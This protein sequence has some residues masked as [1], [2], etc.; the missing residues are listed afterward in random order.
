MFIFNF[1]QGRQKTIIYEQMWTNNEQSKSMFNFLNNALR[2]AYNKKCYF[3]YFFAT[4]TK[5]DFLWTNCEQSNVILCHFIKIHILGY[6]FY[7]ACLIFFFS[8]FFLIFSLILV[9]FYFFFLS[10]FHYHYVPLLFLLFSL[11]YFFLF[12]IY[13]F[14]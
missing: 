13:V 9:L 2:S 14:F 3:Q 5:N 11:L 7:K 6:Q 10:F 1:L 12:F 8:Y 4:K